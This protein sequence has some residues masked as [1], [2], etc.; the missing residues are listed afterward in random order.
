MPNGDY[1]D[2]VVW[3]K[4]FRLV[5]DVYAETS[6]FPGPERYGITSQIRKAAVSIPSNIAEG[7]GRNSRGEFRHHLF[8]ALGSLKELETQLLLADALGYCRQW[9]LKKLLTS[10]AEVGRLINGLTR[11]LTRTSTNH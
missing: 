5:L 11:F 6:N 7:Q 4:S 9:R 1:R 10:S 3:K 2:L 8:I